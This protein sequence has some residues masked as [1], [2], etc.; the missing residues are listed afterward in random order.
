MR[1]RD[2]VSVSLTWL[3][4]CVCD[5]ARTGRFYIQNDAVCCAEIDHGRDTDT[6]I[7][8]TKIVRLPPPLVIVMNLKPYFE[9]EFIKVGENYLI[10]FNDVFLLRN[11][12]III[13]QISTY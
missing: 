5:A 4:F 13:K 9:D 11:I 7:S 8:P 6:P 2:A 10:P 3:W 1:E 12:F